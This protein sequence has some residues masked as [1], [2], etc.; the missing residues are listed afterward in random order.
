M[1]YDLLIR[2]G[3]VV[4]PG[5]GLKGR[6]DVGVSG[7]KIVEVAP[8]LAEKDA[9]RTISARVLSGVTRASPRAASR[10]VATSCSGAASLSMN[11]L[12][13]A[14]RAAYTYSSASNVVSTMTAGQGSCAQMR[15]VAS[16]PSSL[17]IRM[18]ISTTSGD[19]R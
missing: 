19:S 3:E 2:H 14:R 6:L 5:A 7:G 1:K 18:S 17:G 9:R 13:P 15:R 10:M 8:S 11:P 4:D 16:I 12:A